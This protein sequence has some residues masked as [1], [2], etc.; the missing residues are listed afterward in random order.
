[1]TDKNRMADKN[2]PRKKHR[3]SRTSST[4]STLPVIAN[5][6][7]PVTKTTGPLTG[8]RPVSAPLPSDVEL[9]TDRNR[10]DQ[11]VLMDAINN[12]ALLTEQQTALPA[13]A[14]PQFERVRAAGEQVINTPAIAPPREISGWGGGLQTLGHTLNQTRNPQTGE[15][16]LLS[17]GVATLL[18]GLV[19][20]RG[21][22]GEQI[23]LGYDQPRVDLQRQKA[24]EDYQIQSGIL[25]DQ[26]PF[27]RGDQNKVEAAKIRLGGAQAHYEQS[28]GDRRAAIEQENRLAL[29]K[30]QRRPDI[31]NTPAG[32]FITLP[33]NSIKF[34]PMTGAMMNPAQ[35]ATQM[36]MQ[37]DF[38]ADTSKAF[39]GAVSNYGNIRAQAEAAERDAADLERR[40]QSGDVR[41][42][43][44]T[45][46][47]QVDQLRSRARQLY[48]QAFNEAQAIAS[49]FNSG[50]NNFVT[51]TRDAQGRP[52]LNWTPEGEQVLK[53]QSF[54][55]NQSAP[56]NSGRIR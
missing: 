51:V 17:A 10:A 48:D 28:L 35:Y 52:L 43:G 54:L 50:G 9:T 38:N 49:R 5:R 36:R 27:M 30:A 34:A 55:P 16:N 26:L 19:G 37:A 56:F 6:D 7:L 2:S 12:L 13:E 20:D 45:Q 25:K 11:Q 33:D 42:K 31:T 18:G 15:Y 4:E 22:I 29:I 32:A 24:L 21:K 53:N 3:L 14:R 1:M 41:D 8:R 47:V 40:I 23:A 39:S 44:G 46:S